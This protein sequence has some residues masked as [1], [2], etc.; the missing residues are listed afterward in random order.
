MDQIKL[1]R[2]RKQKV[3]NLGKTVRQEIE[4]LCDNQ[5]FVEL[6][7][8]SFSSGN[9]EER[10]GDGVVTGFATI[11][12]YPFYIVA[13]NFDVSLGGLTKA[14]CEKIAR[15][16]NAAEKNE[17]PVV[18]LLHSQGVCLNEGVS[19]LEGISELLLKATQLKGTVPQ[20]AVVLGEVYGSV[21]AL[22]S[23]CDA[24]FFTAQS[25]LALAS[26]LVLSA[27]AGKNLKVEEVGGYD[28]LKNAVLPAVLVKDVKEASAKISA[29]T[30]LFSVSVTEAELNKN[31]PSLNKVA[32]AKALL[33][34]IENPVELGA[35]CYPEVKTVLGRIGGISVAAVIFDKVAISANNMKKIRLFCELACCYGLPLIMLVDCTGIEQSLS[36][37]DST[38]LREISEYLSILDATDTAK[39]SVVTGSAIGIGYSLFAAKSVGF[40]YTYALATSK[41]ALTETAEE[42]DPFLAAQNGYLDNIVEPQFIK[43]YLTASLQMLIR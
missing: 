24:V 27:K 16:L 34:V 1:L 43:Q 37:N 39:I 23:I 21:A 10:I 29:L 28:A 40:D 2:E 9:E 32:D 6:A 17:T 26:P 15:T 13:Q 31:A 8:F 18:Y 38:V 36:V 19:V 33:S 12:G 3:E 41:V 25:K 30:E 20:Y 11:N 5:S 22:A 35:N 4:K 7:A 14:N 42:T